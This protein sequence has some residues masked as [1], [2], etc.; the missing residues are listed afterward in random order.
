MSAVMFLY[1]LKDQSKS[2]IFVFVS[3]AFTVAYVYYSWAVGN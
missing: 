3:Q 1:F 2:D